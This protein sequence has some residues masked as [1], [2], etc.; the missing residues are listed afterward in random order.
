MPPPNRKQIPT[1]NPDLFYLITDDGS[2]SL[3]HRGLDETYHSGCGAISETYHVYVRNSLLESNC[4][5]HQTASRVLE[6]GFGTGTGF[7]LAAALARKTKT[8]LHYVGLEIR[9]LPSEVYAELGLV[10]SL[11]SMK[12]EYGIPQLA[13]EAKDILDRWIAFR[14]SLPELCPPGLYQFEFGEALSMELHIGDATQY[15][16]P[17]ASFDTVFFD[18]FSPKTCPDLWSAPVLQNAYDALKPNGTLVSY[19]VNSQV[20]KMLEGVGFQVERIP[21]PP[22]GKREVLRATKGF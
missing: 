21:G 20:R 19:C 15:A 1:S 12:E 4:I 6:Y 7:F 13:S 2:R 22:L 9:L 5:E 18:A 3:Y 8:P 17:T 14:H 16:S 10:E 11:E